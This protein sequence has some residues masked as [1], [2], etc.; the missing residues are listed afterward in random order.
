MFEGCVCEV[1]K[2][3]FLLGGIFLIFGW[4]LLYI[5]I[6]CKFLVLLGGSKVLRWGFSHCV[7]MLR[8]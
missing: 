5:S 3:G 2:W 7:M 6:R 1:V 8:I 4:G